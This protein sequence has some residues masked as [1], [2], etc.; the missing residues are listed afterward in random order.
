MHRHLLSFA[1]YGHKTWLFTYEKNSLKVF[2]NKGMRI[3]GP[4]SKEVRKGDS[5]K[6]NNKELHKMYTS[7]ASISRYKP[8]GPFCH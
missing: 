2:E 3:F 7:T 1:L 4:N 5:R 6:V 8:T